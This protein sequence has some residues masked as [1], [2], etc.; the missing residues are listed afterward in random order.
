MPQP[1]EIDPN[2]PNHALASKTSP[3]LVN[4]YRRIMLLD[5]MMSL[6]E[7]RYNASLKDWKK[8][9]K[10]PPKGLNVADPDVYLRTKHR[11]FYAHE[12]SVVAKF[13][14]DEKRFDAIIDSNPEF[15]EAYKTAQDLPE[16]QRE[17]FLKAPEKDFLVTLT[18][19]QKAEFTKLK[20]EMAM[21]LD[22][23]MRASYFTPEFISNQPEHDAA[24]ANVRNMIR[25]SVPA[26][27][28]GTKGENAGVVKLF[29]QK[30]QGLK[31]QINKLAEKYPNHAKAAKALLKTGTVTM[32]PSG[33]LI[34]RGIAVI[35]QTK[36][37]KHLSDKIDV[38]VNRVAEKTGLKQ[39]ILDKLQSP[40]GES[41]KKMA[42]GATACVTGVLALTQL[43]D[44]E[45]AQSI[46]AGATEMLDNASMIGESLTVDNGEAI[47]DSLTNSAGQAVD[48]LQAAVSSN[49]PDFGF[50][51]SA[52][53]AI[54]RDVPDAPDTSIAAKPEVF[55]NPLNIDP[56]EDYVPASPTP[57][58]L[59]DG[60]PGATIVNNTPEVASTVTPSTDVP[61]EEVQ[62]PIALSENVYEVQ[63]GDTPSEIAE[64]RLKEAGIP[65]DYDKIMKV[66]HMMAD[67]NGM[68][69][70]HYIQV[71]QDL[72]LPALDTALVDNYQI[73]TPDVEVA[74]KV[75]LTLPPVN[76]ISGIEIDSV[77]SL[78]EEIQSR[79]ESANMVYS[80]EDVDALTQQVLADNGM[81]GDFPDNGAQVSMKMIDDIVAIHGV[82]SQ[83]APQ[84]GITVTALTDDIDVKNSADIDALA[85][86]VEIRRPFDELPQPT[87]RR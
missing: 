22:V 58:D 32:N 37:F 67:A 28:K 24:K 25:A 74:N 47:V 80:S 83:V 31:G 53:E 17:E 38:H 81:K 72:T 79:F 84:A 61:V 87:A 54:A 43:I 42:L 36:A 1:I 73:P 77:M 19:E 10:N 40:K 3:Q 29:S 23:R 86:N 62:A 14:A 85:N 71:G 39:K 51:D 44:V 59:D 12:L 63:S 46:Y 76:D 65:Y 9:I 70:V 18:D 68:D 34:G 35:M 16:S 33:F 75:D 50:G 20:S 45:Q 82:E 52:E 21:G 78:S 8:D 30:Y 6:R 66:V 55:D 69:N 7:A 60:I 56:S 11:Q 48:D 57:T 2:K 15:A 26:G 64:L 41:Y 49:L 27:M 4:M 13:E 5:E